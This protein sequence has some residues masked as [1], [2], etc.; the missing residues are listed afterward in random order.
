MALFKSL[1]VVALAGYL[2]LVAVMYL[3]QR[4]LMYF[5]DRVRTAPDVVGLPEAEE[6]VL[7]TVDGEHVIVWHVA[8]RGERPVLLYFHGNGGALRLRAD[9]FRALTADGQGLVALSYRGYG[10]PA[11][12]PA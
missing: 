2:G 12:A 1:L 11:R 10:G 4:A 3:A 5:P 6:V 8:P 9:R 7:D